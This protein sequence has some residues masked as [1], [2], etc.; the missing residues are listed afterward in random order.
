MG[1][2]WYGLDERHNVIGPIEDMAEASR[3]W[4]L[5]KHVARTKVYEGCEVSTVFLGLD[6]RFGD[7]PPIVFETMVFGG[8]FDQDCD[9]YESWDE[10][11]AGHARIVDKCQP[12]MTE[13]VS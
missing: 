7:G 1:S 4:R 12:I 13:D 11:V 9:R 3:Q 2:G 5:H 10:A 6:H 8:P